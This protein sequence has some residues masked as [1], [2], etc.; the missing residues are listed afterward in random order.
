MELSVYS[1]LTHLP[2]VFGTR[3]YAAWI[4]HGFA[5]IV[6]KN[7]ILDKVQ[8]QYSAHREV[9]STHHHRQSYC[10]QAQAQLAL[11]VVYYENRAKK[12]DFR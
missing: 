4:L 12:P 6:R 9:A 5:K 3:T 8:V 10:L 7:Q 11:F 2:H 1:V